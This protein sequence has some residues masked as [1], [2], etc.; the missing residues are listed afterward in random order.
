MYTYTTSVSEISVA[1]YTVSYRRLVHWTISL[2]TLGSAFWV[3]PTWV[4]L[5]VINCCVYQSRALWTCSVDCRWW[6][7]VS[8]K[9]LACVN[10][11]TILNKDWRKKRNDKERNISVLVLKIKHKNYKNFRTYHDNKF[12]WIAT[13]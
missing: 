1:F 2:L 7:V 13:S 9:M 12:H 4:P 3:L 5:D 6:R 8:E 10:M 11:G